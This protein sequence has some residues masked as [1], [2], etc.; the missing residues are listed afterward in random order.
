MPIILLISN[1]LLNT[2][3]NGVQEWC[4]VKNYDQMAQLIAEVGKYGVFRA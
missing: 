2:Q 1:L 3:I 4:R